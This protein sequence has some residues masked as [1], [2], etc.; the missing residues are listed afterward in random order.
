M[1]CQEK[2]IILEIFLENI[3]Q[4]MTDCL[5]FRNEFTDELRAR[6]VSTIVLL[7]QELS[8]DKLVRWDKLKASVHQAQV[9]P[10]GDRG[11]ERKDVGDS[12]NGINPAH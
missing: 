6:N 12:I 2:N 9:A 8:A 10:I 1:V 5:C 4:V 7:T 11:E 3:V